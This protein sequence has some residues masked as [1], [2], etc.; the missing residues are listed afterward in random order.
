VWDGAEVLYEI[1]YPGSDQQSA[2]S[3]ERD[4]AAVAES[5][6]KLHGRVAYTTG[7]GI[8]QPLALIRFGYNGSSPI[9]VTLHADWR[10]NITRAT[11]P[12]GRDVSAMVPN[13]S[14][15]DRRV[16]AYLNTQ[17]S[18]EPQVWIG[19]LPTGHE[20][21]SGLLYR[22]NRVLDPLTGRF[23]QE[24]PVGLA[25]GLNLY[26]YV[27]GDPVSFSDPFGLFWGEKYWHSF[28][29]WA[30]RTAVR[31]TL[32]I[33]AGLPHSEPDFEDMAPEPPPIEAPAPSPE[34][35]R[36]SLPKKKKT[37]SS[38]ILFDPMDEWYPWRAKERHFP[39]GFVPSPAPG[40]IP[41][42]ILVPIRVPTPTPIFEPIVVLP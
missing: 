38:M 4:T 5:Q 32:V 37:E 13:I 36:D 2:A 6:G 29:R 7:T 25:G 33:K 8:D 34:P 28:T 17:I 16:S 30:Y 20:M 31:I 12:D 40:S 39:F 35:S 22:R 1:R 42:P 18:V 23:T 41:T 26:G 19:D 27:G 10:G 9:G 14:W 15:I 24:D 21:M 11:T 3:L